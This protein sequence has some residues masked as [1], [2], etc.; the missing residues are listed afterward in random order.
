MGTETP[1]CKIGILA[2]ENDIP[3]GHSTSLLQMILFVMGFMKMTACKIRTPF[4]F[5]MPFLGH[6]T[7]THT[8]THEHTHTHCQLNNKT[9]SY[10]TLQKAAAKSVNK[11][12]SSALLHQRKPIHVPQGKATG[13]HYLFPRSEDSSPDVQN[14][15]LQTEMLQKWRAKQQ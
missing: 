5:H 3:L 4:W 15:I 6:L 8:H 13:N 7:H 11:L 1:P 14:G 2:P 10:P 12:V 9:L